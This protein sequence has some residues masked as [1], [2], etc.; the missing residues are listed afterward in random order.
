MAGIKHTS[1]GCVAYDLGQCEDMEITDS[2]FILLLSVIF[3][4]G[5]RI[6]HV[7]R[8]PFRVRWEGGGG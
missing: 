4:D 7:A 6:R 5:K 3:N 8:I 1:P 2:I